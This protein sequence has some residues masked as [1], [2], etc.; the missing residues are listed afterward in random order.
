MNQNSKIEKVPE[1]EE[2][3]LDEALSGATPSNF[4]VNTWCVNCTANVLF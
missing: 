3:I 2:E 1:L 4:N